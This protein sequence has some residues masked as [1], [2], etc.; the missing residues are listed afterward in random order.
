M[1]RISIIL[2]SIL[3]IISTSYASPVDNIKNRCNDKWGANSVMAEYCFNAEVE[4][5]KVAFEYFDQYASKYAG[6][7]KGSKIYNALVNDQPA[8]IVLMCHTKWEDKEYNTWNFMMIEYCIQGQ[9]QVHE[10]IK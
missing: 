3:L 9:L 8:L 2:I 5:A 7:K 4:S 1:K 6:A 10:R